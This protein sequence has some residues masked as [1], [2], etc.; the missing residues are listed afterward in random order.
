VSIYATLWELQFPVSGQSHTDCEW[1][2]VV[3]QGVPDYVGEEGPEDHLAFLPAR[4]ESMAGGLR[5]VV[6]IRKLQ[7]KGTDHSAQE[8]PDPLLTLTGKEY[9][10]LSF[11][12]LHEKLMDAL[13]GSMPR[14]VAELRSPSGATTGFLEDGQ[15]MLIRPPSEA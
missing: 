15:T 9:E 8:Y 10:A 4:E 3:A 1:E 11:G 7:P 13:R 14:M 5:A 2:S 6:F 12:A